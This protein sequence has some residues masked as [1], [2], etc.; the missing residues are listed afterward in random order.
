MTTSTQTLECHVA[1]LDCEHDAAT[2]NRGIE[3]LTG[4]QE[5]KILPKAA[6]IVLT[7]NSAD[8]TAQ[9][10]KEKLNSI[11]FPPLEGRELPE[12]PRPWR[13]PKVVTSAASGLLLLVG[14]LVGWLT[15]ME[16]VS[17]ASYL[18]AIGLGGY[19]FGREALEEL[20]FER[21][22]G[23]ELLMLIAAIAAT[24][25]GQPAEGAM[26]VFLY[27][28]SEAA[29]GYTE[30]KTRSAVRTLMAL[31]PKTAL[32]RR[33]GR[34]IETPVEELGI[35]D[36]FIVKPGQSIATDGEVLTGTS[37]VNQA[38][39][40][41]ESVPV[42]KKT[43]DQVFAAS[44]NGEGAFEVT[45]TR[46]YADNTLSRIIKMVEEAQERR[47]KSQRFIER[48]GAWYSPAVLLI[49]VLVAITLPLVFTLT[50]EE[51]LMRATV[52]IVAAAP[53]ALVISV[54]ITMVA[55]LGAAARRGVLIKGGIY[56]E[57]LAKVQV[58]ALD[59]TGTLTKGEPE[60]T[61]IVLASVWQGEATGED[62][63]L[64]AAA[65]IENRSEHPIARA[66][67][68]R[69]KDADLNL[70]EVA[71]FQSLTGAGATAELN[72]YKVCVG[73]PQLF[74]EQ[75]NVN[76]GTL[77]G[78]ITRL[79]NEGKTVILVGTEC[80]PWGLIAVRDNIRPNARKAVAAFY[81]SGV[82]KVVMLTGDNQLTGE[83]IGRETGIDEVFANLK[84]EDK[85]SM[86]RK[87]EHV[88]MVG[89][90]VNDA[91]A[92]AE[93]DIGVAMG[94]AGT[95][96]A[97]ETADV[98][99]MADDLEKLVY[100]MSLS[101]RTQTIIRQN[102]TLSAIIISALIIGSISGSLSLP[103]VVLAHEVSEFLVIGNG[104]R[105]LRG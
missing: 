22:I 26:L 4:V 53:C 47:G 80:S 92:L 55:A 90:G 62:E 69:A 66:I 81:A 58:V 39:V 32:V 16:M 49:G 73:S 31:A 20:V 50:W 63:L 77:K 100:A 82:R 76:L 65:G 12:L 89:D 33:D 54:P 95:D 19:F 60:V 46:T 96:V 85:A 8:I 25:L 5:I 48:F 2:L 57:E 11:G 34:E 24:A 45:V 15:D 27:S 28:I 88:I 13:N 68:K 105:M 42:E 38:P 21:R 10:L 93:A 14:W 44:I 35:G 29:E 98:A 104:L 75:L 97:L 36:V 61:D 41:G 7:Y 79:Q 102:L 18:C 94:A 91:P 56:L 74:E 101:A 70:P 40:T 71:S 84:P 6:K 17:I 72:G 37:S 59:K 1:N 83:A 43:G 86:V 103:L 3:S 52:F 67:L 87:F 78:D 30:E 51:A 99:L 64:A 9:A 23:I